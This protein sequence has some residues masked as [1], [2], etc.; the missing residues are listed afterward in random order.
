MNKIFLVCMSILSL[1]FI[2]DS[3]EK[4]V[5]EHS[6]TLQVPEPSDICLSADK[7]KYFVVSDNGYLFETDLQFKV[8]RKAD[9]RGLDYEGVYA[10]EKYVYVMDESLRKITLFD[11]AN[12][13]PVKGN[14]L[15]Y[16]GGR[17]KGFESLTYNKDKKRFITT[18]EK[19]PVQ[20]W[21]LD[22]NLNKIMEYPFPAASDLS[23]ACYHD[24]HMY[25]LS[26]ED[27]K[28]FEVNPEDYSIIKTW[29]LPVL[30]PEG[31]TFSPEGNLVIS[32][33]DMS[34]AFVFKPL[35]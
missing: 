31:I 11:V 10:D 12:L 14:T 6:Y 5:P 2:S 22:E 1:S 29:S 27:R 13:K 33:D 28:I 25:L 35:Q 32:S 18:I 15:T 17:N 34:K 21:E 26:D 20:I 23:S 19:G 3:S 4:L 24:G 30:N 7:Q 16:L 9:I 8:T